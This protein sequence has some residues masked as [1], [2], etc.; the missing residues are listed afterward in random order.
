MQNKL[1]STRKENKAPCHIYQI[2]SDGTSLSVSFNYIMIQSIP[3]T[4]VDGWE[5]RH[6]DLPLLLISSNAKRTS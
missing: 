1:S 3:I 4:L 6:S 2:G 5:Q